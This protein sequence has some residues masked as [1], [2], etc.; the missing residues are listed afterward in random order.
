[1]SRRIRQRSP[2]SLAE[3]FGDLRADYDAAK[4]SRYRRSLTGYSAMGSGADYHIRNWT[5]NLRMME[6]ARHFDRNDM[7][8]GQGITRLI[9]N[10]LQGGMKLDPQTGDDKVDADLAA[11]WKDWSEDPAKC[12]NAAE[13]DLQTLAQLTLRSVI[14]DGDEFILPLRENG[15]LELIEA[16]RC[17]TPTNTRLNVVHGVMLD[18]HRK[19]LEF[20]F[21]KDN[22][23]PH[24]NVQR[25]GDMRRYPARH[26]DTGERQVLQV[27][28]PKRV[29]Q[30]RGITHLAPIGNAVGMHDDLEFANLVRAQVAACYAVF[31]EYELGDDGADPPQR[32]EASTETLLDGSTRTVEGIAPGMDI[33]GKPGERLEGFSPNIP[34]PEFFQHARLILTF[35]AINLD[36]PV[37]VLLLDPSQTN[38]SGWRG[39]MDQARFG[40]RDIQRWMIRQFYRPIYHWQIRQWAAVDTVLQGYEKRSDVDLFAHKWHPPTW[41]YIEPSKDVKADRNE[42]EGNIN[43]LRRINAARGR[44]WDDVHVEIIE[45]RAKLARRAL[46]EAKK[47]NQE[48]PEAEIDFRELAG[49]TQQK[50]TEDRSDSDELESDRDKPG[51]S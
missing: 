43:S 18:E 22:I 40:F 6:L 23:P 37:Q 24:Q 14:V 35:I 42:V 12:D 41:P 15:S 48:F 26:P 46:E 39:A 38:F 29:S 13:H 17:R 30:T 31:H 51:A 9:R 19:R 34:N 16:H 50:Q 21:T 8:V 45:D 3:A 28:N 25:V 1:M 11:R 32:G 7:I 36:I 33:H 20:W 4:G 27:Y 10:V 5:D 49:W 47:I 44:D 2:G